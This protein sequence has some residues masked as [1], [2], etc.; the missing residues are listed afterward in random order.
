MSVELLARFQFALTIAF[1]YIFPPMS[2]GL[3]LL[4][5]VLEASYL[6]TKSPDLERAVRFWIKIFGVIFAMGVASGIVMEFQFGTNWAAYSRFVGDV[7]GSALAAEGVFAFFLESG[8]LAIL[9]FGWNRVKPW[10]HMLSTVM[11]ALGAT[12]S[13]VWIIVANSW[14]QTPAGF[15]IGTHHGS[16]KALI[17]DFW[18][19]VFNPSAMDRLSHTVSAA[20]ITGAFLMMSVAAYYLIKNKHVEIAKPSMKAGLALAV[21]AI[22]LQFVTGHSSVGVV[23]KHQ[24]SKLAAFENH[25]DSS[26]PLDLVILGVPKAGGGNNGLVIPGGGSLLLYGDATKPVK[27]FDQIPENE[28]PPIAGTYHAYHAMVIIGITLFGLTAITALLALTGKLWTATGWLKLLVPAVIL[29][30]LGNQLGWIAAE[31]GRQP[32]IVWGLMRTDDGISKAV[33]GEAVLTSIILFSAIY[34]LLFY[35]FIYLMDK[36]IKQ[37]PDPAPSERLDGP[38]KLEPFK[39]EVKA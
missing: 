12:F 25:W 19:M 5:V 6:K 39:P 23:A 32:W 24:P 21:V 3:G 28:R 37:G 2:I 4:L 36:K 34:G 22:I 33:K 17:T 26:K 38:M 18:A 14:M 8:F 35:L 9:V 20:W 11:V 27:G 13:A 15:E 1:H 16:Q 7:F 29:P 30:H 31:V 10:V